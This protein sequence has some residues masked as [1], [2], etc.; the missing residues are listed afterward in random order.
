MDLRISKP[1]LQKIMKL[2]IIPVFRVR[3][4]E[5][6]KSLLRALK[7]ATAPDAGYEINLTELIGGKSLETAIDYIGNN[8]IVI[9]YRDPALGNS[10]NGRYA[11]VDIGTRQLIRVLD[12]LPGDEPYEQGFLFRIKSCI[13]L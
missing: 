1:H 7:G 10:Y 8:K 12:E 3:E 5:Q 11:I 4:P 6:A 2:F 9:L 13:S